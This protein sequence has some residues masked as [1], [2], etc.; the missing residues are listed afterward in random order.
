MQDL[1]DKYLTY[2]EHNKGRAER[3]VSKYRGYLQQLVTWCHQKEVDPLDITIEQLED[4]TGRH[5]HEQG[6]KPSARRPL[7]AAVRGFYEWATRYKHIK[8]NPAHILSYPQI[9]RKMPIPIQLHNA[10]K[11]LMQCDLHTFIGVRDYAMLTV[12][13]GCGVRV[14]GLVGINQNDLFFVFENKKEYLFIKVREKGKKERYIPAPHETR[15]SIKAYLAHPELNTIDRAL[16]DG[17]QVLFVSTN[18]QTVP[19]HEYYGA[20][21]RLRPAAINRIMYQYGEKAGIPKDQRN[22]H[23]A[24]HLYGTEL[25]E[26]D[27]LAETRQTLLGHTDIKTTAIYTS[28][29]MR[30]LRKAVDQSNPLSKMK[31]PFT[32]IIK[33]LDHGTD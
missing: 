32:G 19:K 5:A 15:L 12:L 16:P 29:A 10:E 1:I 31:T 8:A 26:D 28:L 23:A 4:F 14:S 11:M 3:T 22:P 18:N 6:L 30:K 9:G 20:R 27:V 2:L 24:R 33:R 17:D 25:A 13:F 7:V 21:R